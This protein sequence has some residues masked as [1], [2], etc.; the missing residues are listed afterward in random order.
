M[1]GEGLTCYY[2]TQVS[3]LC[4]AGTYG[5]FDM[6]D[7]ATGGTR[8]C[9]TCPGG[10][11]CATTG[12]TEPTP[13]GKGKYSADGEATACSDCEEGYYCEREDTSQT[14]M[15]ANSCSAGYECP[16]GTEERPF[17]D[18]E[19]QWGIGNKYSCPL[20]HYC[21][22]GVATPCPTGTYNPL[23]GAQSDADCFETPAGYY[24]DQEGSYDFINNRCP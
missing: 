20:G 15:N 19:D 14:M 7:A 16:V 10:Y 3:V 11:L 1:C 2:G 18:H 6:L 24:T 13:C 4:P 22:A 12:M 21:T 23:Y 8:N 9:E 17:Y 5:K